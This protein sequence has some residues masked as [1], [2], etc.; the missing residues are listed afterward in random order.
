LADI[1]TAA[2]EE[3]SNNIIDRAIDDPVTQECN[4]NN[5]ESA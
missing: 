5:E 4:E 2:E 1:V 3:E